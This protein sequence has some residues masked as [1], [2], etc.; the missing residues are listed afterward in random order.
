MGGPFSS[1]QEW[2]SQFEAEH[3]RK[4]TE[5]DK[6]IA[7]DSFAFWR[8]T[9]RAPTDYEWRYHHYTGKWP[10]AASGGGWGGGGG[11]GGSYYPS[12]EDS[13]VPVPGFNPGVYFWRFGT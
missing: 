4:P 6:S 7:L 12:G 10:R 11:G 9:G 5:Q 8:E 13:A 3:G 1:E 2:A